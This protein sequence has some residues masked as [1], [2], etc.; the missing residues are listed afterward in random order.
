MYHNIVWNKPKHPTDF[1]SFI[2]Q[3]HSFNSRQIDRQIS[4]A[5]IIW[6]LSYFSKNNSW[7]MEVLRIFGS[8]DQQIDSWFT[9]HE[10]LIPTL[11]N[12]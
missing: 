10:P 11:I 3:S 2:N 6:K 8:W 1:F 9:N 4:P 5:V 7:K 12:N